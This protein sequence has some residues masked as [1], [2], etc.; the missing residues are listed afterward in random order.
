MTYEEAPTGAKVG[1]RSRQ[2]WAQFGDAFGDIGRQFHQDYERVTDTASEGSDESQKSIERAV[3]AIRAAIESTGKTIGASLRDP[4]VKQE[5][6]EAG[7]ALMQAVGVSLSELG[8]KLQHDA[9]H[10][11]EHSA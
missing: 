5:T 10:E 11:R 8:E 9:D 1:S 6:K 2:A 4:R 3:R 7:S